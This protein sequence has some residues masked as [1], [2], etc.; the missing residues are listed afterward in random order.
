[1]QTPAAI[2]EV[3]PSQVKS[4]REIFNASLKL[5]LSEFITWPVQMDQLFNGCGS[6]SGCYVVAITNI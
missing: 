5:R 6:V 1:M 2:L 3:S 4:G